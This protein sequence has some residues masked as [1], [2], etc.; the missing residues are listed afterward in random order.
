MRKRAD[1]LHLLR[2]LREIQKCEPWALPMAFVLALMEA[3]IP[4]GAPVLSAIFVDGLEQRA[5][6]KEL[7]LAAVIGVVILFIM[8]VVRGKMFRCGLPHSEYCN[9]L[10][11]W[12]FN[13]KS[14]DMDYAR[15]DSAETAGLRARIQNDYDWGC[16]AYYMIPQ[17]QRC[18]AGVIG[19]MASAAFLILVL[20]QGSFWLDWSTLLFFGYV[21]AVTFFSASVEK[22]TFQEEETL[23]RQ[24]DKTSSRANY[25]MRGGITYREGKDIRIYNAQP[26]IKSALREEERDRMVEGESRLEQRAGALDGAASGILMGGAYVFVVLRSLQGALSAGAVVLFASSI[27]RFSESLKILAKS[28]SEILMNARRM[29]STFAYLDLPGLLEGGC[30]PAGLEAGKGEIEFRDVSF[31]YPGAGKP[32]LS[33]VSFRLHPGEKTAVV[34]MNGSG[35]TTLVKL[36]C[37]LYDPSEGSILLNG[38]DIRE[39]EYE[40]YMRLFS[41]VFQDFKLLAQP[42]GENVAAAQEYQQERVWECLKKAGFAARLERMKKGL[43]TSLY[44]DLDEEGVEVS[45]GEAQKI[46]LARALYK[47][48]P[49]VVLD[50]PTAALDPISEHEIYSG[51]HRL[52]GDK[53][54]VFI[55]HRLSSCRFCDY[56]LVL[57]EGELVQRGNHEELLKEDK[58]KYAVMWQAQARYY[59]EDGADRSAANGGA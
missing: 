34:G 18:C 38:T 3:L 15:L 52:I 28:R 56:I 12:K 43:A 42:L 53:T 49:I 1:M 30:L 8:N 24:F 47:D 21:F 16:G 57:H 33:H 27:Y 40:E 11:E 17:F 13:D 35:K 44:R 4:L 5:S 2:C 25:L 59:E 32:A 14:M 39:Y 7:A 19:I 48:A 46:A 36:L 22:R 26:L 37:R 31:T 23:K 58:G 54:A 41:V 10:M 50:E 51:F 20:F 29:E 6:F 9:D 45:G 55:S